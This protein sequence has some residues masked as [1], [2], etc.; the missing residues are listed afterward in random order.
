MMQINLV[1]DE[2]LKRKLTA[3]HA[4]TGDELGDFS[5]FVLGR[6]ERIIDEEILSQLGYTDKVEAPRSTRERATQESFNDFGVASG[7]SNEDILDE[8]EEEEKAPTAHGLSRE[9]L[10]RDMVISDP[11]KEAVS[12]DNDNTT[13][14]E[15]MGLSPLSVND[16]P[17][18]EDGNAI[19][20]E[21][22]PFKIP[23]IEDTPP[24]RQNVRKLPAN[25]KAQVFNYGGSVQE[26]F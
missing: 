9:M 11:R 24:K 13:F 3:L 8:E 1:I 23:V 7:L 5:D 10:E 20:G 4:L 25:C 6:M 18:D 12:P 15:L 19:V 21:E 2:R 17:V 16:L 14:E 22:N 26:T